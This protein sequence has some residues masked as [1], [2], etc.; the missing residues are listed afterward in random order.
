MGYVEN[1][2]WSHYQCVVCPCMGKTL[3]CSICAVLSMLLLCLTCNATCQLW[4][5]KLGILETIKFRK[6][7]VCVHCV[8][9]FS[10]KTSEIA[11]VALT[12]VTSDSHRLLPFGPRWSTPGPS[13]QTATD[14][15]P[16]GSPSLWSALSAAGRT[17][18]WRSRGSLSDWGCCGCR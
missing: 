16:L 14:R 8:V 10:L 15:W 3:Y 5:A 7:N 9:S 6:W 13:Q 12:K 2:C 17:P 1:T 18:H 11:G 4:S